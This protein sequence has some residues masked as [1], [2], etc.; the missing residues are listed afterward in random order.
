MADSLCPYWIVYCVPSELCLIHSMFRELTLCLSSGAMLYHSPSHSQILRPTNLANTITTLIFQHIWCNYFTGKFYN[1]WICERLGEW[2]NMKQSQRSRADSWNIVYIGHTSETGQ[3]PTQQGHKSFKL[4]APSVVTV[5]YRL[6]SGTHPPASTSITTYQAEVQR[7]L[8][9]RRQ[10]LLACS[11]I[12]ISD[13]HKL[14][15]V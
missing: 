2:H 3:C 11:L 5:K 15:S 9:Y 14:W 13:Y 10:D 8:H 12:A 4:S 1:S 6:Q 7:L